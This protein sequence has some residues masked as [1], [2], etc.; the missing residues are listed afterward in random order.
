MIVDFS[1]TLEQDQH[2]M[3]FKETF[4][5]YQK[6]V[7]AGIGKWTP[8]V[9]ERPSTLHRAMRYSMEAGG[10]RI[11]P[12]LLLAGHDLYPS[13]IDPM[14]AAV[15]V[16]C[17]HTYSLIHDDL[18]AMDDSDLRRGR[19]A[20]H[21]QF[22]EATA[23][24]AGDALM[25]YAFSLLSEAYADRPDL[26]V[27]LI[28]ELSEAAGS[29]KLIGGQMADIIHE[30]ND[31]TAEELDFIHLNKTAALISASL[32]MGVMLSGQDGENLPLARRV[33]SNIG[34]AF[35]IIDDILDATSTSEN[36]GKIAGQDTI[37][38]KNTYVKLHGLDKSRERAR[39]VTTEAV[40]DC[41]KMKGDTRFLIALIEWLE[42]RIN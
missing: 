1:R 8:P 28:R 26:A 12:V 7:E 22:D 10:K 2:D 36:L 42:H 19:P 5:V 37:N 23:V 32:S 31:C 33:G 21:V 24:L 17:L 14:P 9:E 6:Q 15:A 29:R 41:Q 20:C 11:R 13:P 34:L 3:I 40:K 18:P 27:A 35:Q 25:T 16:E 38:D 30:K 39:E 4:E